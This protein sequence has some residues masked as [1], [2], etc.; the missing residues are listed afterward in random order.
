MK[1]ILT[2]LLSAIAL[3]ALAQEKYSVV[4]ERAQ[5]LS[6]YEAIY[7]L[8]DYQQ[9]KPQ[10][11]NIYYQLGNRCYGL[12]PA[13]DA[14]HD[15]REMR[16]LLY[17]S[18][19]FYGN[20][21]PF[22]KDQKL[23]GWQYSEIAQGEKKIDYPALEAY[24]RPRMDEVARLQTACDSIHR[25]F[26][27]LVEQYNNCQ[28]LY[29]RFLTQYTREKTA[30]LQLSAS[31]RKEL[32]QLAVMSAQLN[33]LIKA[34]QGALALE[35][36]KDY[37]PTFRWQPIELYR[38][39]GLTGSD[40]MRNDITLWDYHRWVK[41]FLDEQTNMYEKLYADIQ[42]EHNLLTKE[43]ERYCT[44]SVVSNRMDES[45]VGRCA[46]LEVNTPQSRALA[47][48]QAVVR[49]GATE[50]Q[51]AESSAPANIRGLVPH[52]RLF[53]NNETDRTHITMA[54]Y[55]S[56]ADSALRLQKQHIIRMA[57]PLAASQKATHTSPIDGS[58]ISYKSPTGEAVH[59][60]QNT[61][62]GW[63]C[64]VIDP[65]SGATRVLRLNYDM[66]ERTTLL[67][68]ANERPIIFTGMPEGGWTLVTDKN[69]YF[70]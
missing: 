47:S 41:H 23:P 33:G 34:Y 18:R 59:A 48:M 30:H 51:L 52:L 40:F 26:Y 36:I 37:N 49:I 68:I 55:Q 46:R 15:Y 29:S 69:I 24:I 61:M 16:E 58:V 66:S 27:R 19:L 65:I 7:L 56:I 50:I 4:L 64:V 45:L 12:L 31:E 8:M 63:R 32:E 38:M 14:L 17:R 28:Q 70:L 20:C 10:E 9:D 11:A 60:L 35:P 6:P 13:R 21:L 22:A 44:G 1:K 5:Q 57:T 53:R 42:R 54:E 3:T 2:I 39:D 62:D 43:I 67:E 25:S